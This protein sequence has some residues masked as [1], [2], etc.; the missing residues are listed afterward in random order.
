MTGATTST[1]ERA[2]SKP[3]RFVR[4]ADRYCVTTE[5]VATSD[6]RLRCPFRAQKDGAHLFPGRCPGL[7]AALALRAGRMGTGR[8]RFGFI[9]RGR[10]SELVPRGLRRRPSVTPFW[11]LV[12]VEG[13]PGFRSNP[14][15]ARFRS[16]PWAKFRRPY[17]G[18]PNGSP[19]LSS[20]APGLYERAPIQTPV[21][22]A[23]IRVRTTVCRPYRGYT[24]GHLF[25]HR[26][27]SR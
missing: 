9:Q 13:D 25:R 17:R 26:S 16:P 11:G 3:T 6:A 20:A 19:G 21:L 14:P 8:K 27:Y 22:I 18:F 10:G 15:S 5:T 12:L 24:T 7:K 4:E 23:L 2:H 1:S